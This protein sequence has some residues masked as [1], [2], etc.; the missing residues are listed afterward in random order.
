V[1][2]YVVTIVT[3]G[4]PVILS[5]AQFVI[6]PTQTKDL[7]LQI[8]DRK[9]Q[10]YFGASSVWVLAE[11]ALTVMRSETRRP[12]AF[13]RAMRTAVS[14][15]LFVGTVPASSTSSSVTVTRT[16]EP[17]KVG[18]ECSLL[19]ICDFTASDDDVGVA[20]GAG[21]VAVAAG[22][23]LAG[24]VVEVAG[25]SGVVVVCVPDLAVEAV[26]VAASGA[27][28]ATVFTKRCAPSGVAILPR[29]MVRKGTMRPYRSRVSSLQPHAN[30]IYWNDGIFSCSY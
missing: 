9:C 15:S 8:S 6:Q 23:L 21:L 27:Y 20:P 10:T 14:R 18:S 11:S 17:S 22:V 2:D 16:P 1:K 29:R 19:S 26:D 7:Q 4:R 25:R 30:T 12:A 5:S 3:C 28:F 13:S 24:V